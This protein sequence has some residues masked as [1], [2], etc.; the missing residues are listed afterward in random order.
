MCRAARCGRQAKN[1]RSVRIGC[2]AMLASSRS[3]FSQSALAAARPAAR[4]PTVRLPHVIR[5]NAGGF[6]AARPFRQRAESHLVPAPLIACELM[7]AVQSPLKVV[8][9]L[10]LSYSCNVM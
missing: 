10:C 8:V 6:A 7:Q 9:R 3:E 2:L 4:Q 1:E 5:R